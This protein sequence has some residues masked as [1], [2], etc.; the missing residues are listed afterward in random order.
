M[1]GLGGGTP[2]QS[3]DVTSGDGTGQVVYALDLP[4]TT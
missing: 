1:T 4:R 3:P 2:N